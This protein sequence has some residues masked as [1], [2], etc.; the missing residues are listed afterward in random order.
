MLLRKLIL[1]LSYFSFPWA[2][3]KAFVVIQSGW[4]FKNTSNHLAVF[5]CLEKENQHCGTFVPLSGFKP[6][7]LFLKT[8]W[9]HKIPSPHVLVYY[10]FPINLPQIDGSFWP[11]KSPK[12]KNSSFTIKHHHDEEK[13]KIPTFKLLELCYVSEHFWPK[14][15]TETIN[16]M[17]CN[18]VK[19]HET[20]QR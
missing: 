12:S 19:L 3:D 7:I 10:V 18:S 11:A 6:L 17:S 13:Q 20:C 5:S 8:F 2:Q 16:W 1:S 15:T 14:K 4:G 9:N